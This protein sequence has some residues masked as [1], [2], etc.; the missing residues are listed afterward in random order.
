MGPSAL[1]RAPGRVGTPIVL[2]FPGRGDGAGTGDLPKESTFPRE[3]SSASSGR[4]G[5]Q[6]GLSCGGQRTMT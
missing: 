4:A 2:K 5:A 1:P 3:G 6:V